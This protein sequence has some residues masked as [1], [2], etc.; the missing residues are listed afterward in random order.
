M[1]SPLPSAFASM[2]MTPICVLFHQDCE[3]IVYVISF[4]HVSVVFPH[5]L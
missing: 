4:Q 5:S 1:G 2:S 3:G